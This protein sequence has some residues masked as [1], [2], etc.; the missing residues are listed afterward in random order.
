M[1]VKLLRVMY[2]SSSVSIK[3][4]PLPVTADHNMS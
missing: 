1:N 3:M 2:V 4:A